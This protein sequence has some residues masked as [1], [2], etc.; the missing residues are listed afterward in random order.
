MSIR[1][2]LTRNAVRWLPNPL[3]SDAALLR[4]VSR[5]RGHAALPRS[6]C[7]RC[8]VDT[9]I[10]SGCEV[11]TL[12]PHTLPD[13]APRL[14]Y[15]HGGAYVSPLVR[16]HWQILDQLMRRTAMSVTVPMYGLAPQQTV[17]DAYGLLDALTDR[18]HRNLDADR[19]VYAGDSAGGG[20]ALSY[21]IRQRDNDVAGAD[22]VVLFAPWV[23]VTLDNP[24]IA[25]LERTDVMLTTVGLRQCGKWWAGT[26]ELTDPAVSP[27]HANLAGLPP[28]TIFQGDRDLFLPDVA[29]LDRRI[30]QAGGDCRMNIAEGGFHVYMGA[31]WIPEAQEALDQTAA[32]IA[33]TT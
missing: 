7:R 9:E 2:A 31:P 12:R 5:P 19:L 16:A 3:Q 30:R 24:D 14:I 8:T 33:A 32:V 6:L 26:R 13:N 11:L 20:L 15:L 17:D 28:I 22:A 18:H 23:D 1:M 21:A 4:A 27:L 10:I 29:V 25:A